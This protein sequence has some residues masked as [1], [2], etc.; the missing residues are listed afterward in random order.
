VTVACIMSDHKISGIII[1]S[2]DTV[3][4]ALKTICIKQRPVLKDLRYDIAKKLL[5][6]H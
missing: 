5:I 6:W 1:I 4:P 2:L 3:K